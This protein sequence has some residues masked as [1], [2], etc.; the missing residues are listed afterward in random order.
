MKNRK[1]L[2]GYQIV[3]G[4]YQVLEQEAKIV[5]RMFRQYQE[6]ASYQQLANSFNQ[7]GVSYSR[8]APEWNKNKVKRLLEN[9]K[10]VG[11]DIYPP[12][13]SEGLFREVQT[14]IAEKAN[15][16]KVKNDDIKPL[17]KFLRCEECGQPLVRAGGS[18]AA[19]YLQ[20]RSCNAAV[21]MPRTELIA[22][23][24][25][26]R[27]LGRQQFMNGP[28]TS[29]KLARIENQIN[30]SLECPKDP[31]E[32]VRL[33]LQEITAR[34]DC[35]G[36]VQVEQMQIKHLREIDWSAFGQKVSHITISTEKTVSMHYIEA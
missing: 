16:Q 12:I 31:E 10:Y 19:I 23:V 6:G 11:T 25:D 9:E 17:M 33:I 2:Y 13:I 29:E 4:A 26:Q 30:R 32:I 18:K 22:A 35:C 14:I 20:C 27:N 3:H 21:W 8:D 36:P 1:I 24:L 28:E 5:K 34:Y 7:E 15:N